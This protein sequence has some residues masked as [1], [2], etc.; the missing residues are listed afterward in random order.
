[1][2]VVNV[3]VKDTG[4]R[5]REQSTPGEKGQASSHR[6]NNLV[7]TGLINHGISTC[8]NKIFFFLK[9]SEE[10]LRR[11]H[12]W[13][14]LQE[15]LNS[16]KIPKHALGYWKGSTAVQQECV[17]HV[18]FILTLSH[19][20]VPEFADSFWIYTWQTLITRKGFLPHAL[21]LPFGLSRAH[22]NRPCENANN[23]GGD[24]WMNESCQTFGHNSHMGASDN[25][26]VA[27][28]WSLGSC[29]QKYNGCPILKDVTLHIL[30]I[31]MLRRKEEQLK[32]FPVNEIDL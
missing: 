27:S 20:D 29:L 16:P 5:M 4:K 7:L 1:M 26:T 2:S 31:Y 25:P 15:L 12:T 18:G 3:S 23:T 9:G 6:L 8:D 22:E 10:L 13:W 17:W 32:G 19:K 24:L 14:H 30:Q 28:A 21:V 11:R